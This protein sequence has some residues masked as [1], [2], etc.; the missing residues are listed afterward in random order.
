MES[1]G[2]LP[3]GIGGWGT[4]GGIFWLSFLFAFLFG[5]VYGYVCVLYFSV[6]C[7]SCILL[8]ACATTVY[9]S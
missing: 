2:A 8:F 7:C 9:K 6:C 4:V 3:E 5:M 1:L